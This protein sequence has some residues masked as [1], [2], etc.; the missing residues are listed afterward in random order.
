MKKKL[1]SPTERKALMDAGFPRQTALNWENGPQ[2][3]AGNRYAIKLILKRDIKFK[4]NRKKSH[5][6][7][8]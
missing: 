6:K 4:R 3:R 5:G 2:P 7:V 1:F 8:A